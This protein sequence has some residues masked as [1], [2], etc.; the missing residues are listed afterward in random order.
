MARKRNISKIT[1]KRTV[2]T[3]LKTYA[4][5]E[6]NVMMA[7]ENKNLSHCQFLTLFF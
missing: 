5:E 1:T 3:F 6:E 7:K 2:S 4:H